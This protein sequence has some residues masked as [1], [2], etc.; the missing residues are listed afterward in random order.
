MLNLFSG[1]SERTARIFA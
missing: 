1:I